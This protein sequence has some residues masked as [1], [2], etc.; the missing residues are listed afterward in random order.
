MG[1]RWE[2]I[3]AGSEPKP[4][5]VGPLT[6]TDAVRY[7]GASGDMNPVHHDSEFAKQAGF[8][9]PLMVGMFQ[10]GVLNTWAT[11]WLGPE[12]VRRTKVRWREPV[13]PGDVL[14]CSGTVAKKYEEEGERR[15]DLE[16]ACTNQDGKAAV[17]GWMT[18]V[19]PDY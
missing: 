17:Q 2:D 10:A 5:V 8:D 9:V 1:V 7:Q 15:V 12:N 19:V 4:M 3:Q 11:N 6:V 13:F 18:F 16:L 14:T